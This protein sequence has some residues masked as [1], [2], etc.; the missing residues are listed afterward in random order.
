MVRGGWFVYVRVVS[1]VGCVRDYR[2]LLFST[3]IMLC[4][5]FFF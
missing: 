3:M 1:F 4:F 2:V 5:L